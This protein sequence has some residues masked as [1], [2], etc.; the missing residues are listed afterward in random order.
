MVVQFA[1]LSRVHALKKTYFSPHTV[2]D[3]AGRSRVSAFTMALFWSVTYCY[4]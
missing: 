1:S 2:H 4:R 3:D